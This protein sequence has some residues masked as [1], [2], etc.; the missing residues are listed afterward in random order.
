[1]AQ[2]RQDRSSRG[3]V[4]PTDGEG[5]LPGGAAA[6]L[7]PAS[8]RSLLQDGLLPAARTDPVVFRAFLRMFNL[9]DPPEKLMKDPDLLARV[10]TV[11]QDRANH[12]PVEPAGPDRAGLLAT[13]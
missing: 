3:I 10:L 2:D 4:V 11:W 8:V 13:L 9:L 12:P 7:D 6:A 1:M 5:A